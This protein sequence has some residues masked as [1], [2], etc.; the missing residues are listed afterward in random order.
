MEWHG[1]PFYSRVNKKPS[2]NPWKKGPK[3]TIVFGATTETPGGFRWNFEEQTSINGSFQTGKMFAKLVHF[4]DSATQ[5]GRKAIAFFFHSHRQVMREMD[6]FSWSLS[7]IDGTAPATK[8]PKPFQHRCKD[9]QGT[10]LNLY[11]YFTPC[12]SVHQILGEWCKQCYTAVL[13][14]T[15]RGGTPAWAS[16]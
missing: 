5:L 16:L 6:S 11:I 13:L 8:N 9:L 12:V 7:C 15:W 10:V 1:A 4:M 2:K 3:K 14:S